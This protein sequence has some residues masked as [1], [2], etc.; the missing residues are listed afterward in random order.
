MIEIV[1]LEF[2]TSLPSSIAITGDV[3]NTANNLAF[4]A[5][6]K[7]LFNISRIRCSARTQNA[8]ADDTDLIIVPGLG[9]SS[10]RQLLKKIDSP[11]CRRAGE[12]LHRA[13]QSGTAIA[14][15]CASTFLLA[16]TGILNNRR[17]TTPWYLAGSFRHRYP[18]VEL[19]SEKVVVADWPVAT[20]GAAMAQM[21]LML[22]I[23]SKFG[24]QKLSDDCAR[25]LLLDE[26]QSQT[27]FISVAHLAGQDAKIAKAESW[28]R[29]HIADDFGVNDVAAAVAMTPRTF[30]RRLAVTCGLS[31]VRFVQRIRIETAKTLLET[32]RQP[33]DEIARQVG[34]VE[35]S[36]LRKL[37]RRETNR[38]PGSFRPG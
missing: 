7:P 4:A 33:V 37:L 32:T 21:D 26:R 22:A 25:Y 3:L 17:A 18:N 38:S 24:K 12:I 13:F 28:I 36:T 31:P 14:A 2:D 16:E 20:A 11:A 1:V 23:V 35:P 19:A 30:A 5:K 10:E 8:V 29:K 15:S 34:Y 6:R 9:I 27:P